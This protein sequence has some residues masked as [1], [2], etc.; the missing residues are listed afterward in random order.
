MVFDIIIT[1]K[2]IDLCGK[3]LTKLMS[4]QIEIDM[5]FKSVDNPVML[6]PCWVYC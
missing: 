2:L 3:L 5:G 4:L 6:E 1:K